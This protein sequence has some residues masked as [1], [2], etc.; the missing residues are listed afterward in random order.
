MVCS[1][2]GTNPTTSK[3]QFIPLQHINVQSTVL[4]CMESTTV[5][6]SYTNDC[7]ETLKEVKYNF[8][9]TTG[10]I[11]TSLVSKFSSGLVL[12]G[13]FTEK[14]Q[15]RQTYTAAKEANKVT[16]LLEKNR[17]G[18]YTI[19][20]GNFEKETSIELTISFINLIKDGTYVFPTNICPKYMPADIGATPV[21]N[22]YSQSIPYT[23]N[24][25]IDWTTSEKIT[26]VDIPNKT[27]DHLVDQNSDKHA[28][29][30]INSVPQNGDI[31]IKLVT[32]LVGIS[33][34]YSFCDEKY[35]YI[36]LIKSVPEVEI[37][38]VVKREFIFLLDRSG[39]MEGDKIE[40]AKKAL[41]L[42]LNS[43]PEN[44]TFNVVSFGSS[45]ESM[46]SSP[47]KY[48]D[49]NLKSA[50]SKIS[51][52]K[53]DLGGTEVFKPMDNI[54]SQSIDESTERILILLTD[55]D[56]GQS[57]TYLRK[58]KAV[59]N[60]R[61][62]CV[63]IGSGVD[64]NA[65]QRIASKLNGQCDVI[66]NPKDMSTC[67]T[68]YLKTLKKEIISVNSLELV[69]PDGK[70][71]LEYYGLEDRGSYF[72][73]QEFISFARVPLSD[74]QR[75]TSV[76][77]T[78]KSTDSNTYGVP[79]PKTDFKTSDNKLT[80]FYGYSFVE[81][82]KDTDQTKASSIS[83]EIGLVNDY[84][85]LLLVGEQTVEPG[86]LSVE[87]PHTQCD[88]DDRQMAMVSASILG[89]LRNQSMSL[90]VDELCNKSMCLE[91][92]SSRSYD[93]S[94]YSAPKRG[95]VSRGMS[96]G[97]KSAP[98][99]SGG[100]SLP[101]IN[102][103]NLGISEKLASAK[104]SLGAAWDNVKTTLTPA[105]SSQYVPL[106]ILDLQNTDGS[107]Q[108]GKDLLRI[109]GTTNEIVSQLAT[110]QKLPKHQVIYKLLLEFLKGKAEYQIIYEK[111]LSY[112]QSKFG[113]CTTSA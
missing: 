101:S 60:L 68:K 3:Q 12:K 38:N 63:G 51:T 25:S 27:S 86:N 103:P 8:T 22:A 32:E 47:Q 46:F 98:Q 88:S 36:G 49:S 92:C 113:T 55:G 104:K 45:Y 4:N 80:K 37:S 42:F 75:A 105:P 10:A 17:D 102:L 78:F 13:T 44:S 72:A 77:L 65:L 1:L 93:K 7:G 57:N 9:L 5:S 14:A 35:G 16:H 79:L 54:I 15:A 48:T 62:F 52:F 23:F 94:S 2:A 107:F 70:S 74:Y 30:N 106:T 96:L 20:I 58:Y 19:L 85:S 112:Y 41:T 81:S 76:E 91:S 100:F 31:I 26:G 28:F 59:K 61:L 66:V 95:G 83:V 40:S 56:V 99:S 29:V 21:Q 33:T 53:A 108:V 89:G 84:C 87:V 71:Q 11:I 97:A 111:T 69:C 64:R 110:D 82:I 34:V 43:L 18:S 109:I 67:I 39:S 6:Q 73:G 24:A 50:R 90:Q